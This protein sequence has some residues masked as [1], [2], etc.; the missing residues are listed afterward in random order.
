MWC[1][2]RPQPDM[3]TRVASTRPK[4]KVKITELVKLRKLHFSMSISY[5]KFTWSSK[6]MV[7]YDGMGPGLHHVRARFWN[8]LLEKL[9]SEFKLREM[10][11]FQMAIFSYCS[12][13]V[14]HAGIVG[15]VHANMT[16]TR[17]KFKVKVT[18][19]LKF[20]KSPCWP[21]LY[22]LVIVIAGRPQQAVHS[23][24]DD[25]QPPCVA[26]YWIL[27]APLPTLSKHSRK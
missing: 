8:F 26:F 17:S 1:V 25:R 12:H 19:L 10:S 2:G 27:G 23:G 6:L 4:A 16:L 18:D 5:A 14:R 22:K 21:R 7:V 20:I 24:G 11:I 3:R 9:S 15:T 13:M